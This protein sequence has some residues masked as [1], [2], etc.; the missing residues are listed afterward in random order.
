MIVHLGWSHGCCPVRDTGGSLPC[1]HYLHAH[2]TGNKKI[3]KAF[4]YS[5]LSILGSRSTVFLSR[6]TAHS[7]ILY[8]VCA[9]RGAG[10]CCRWDMAPRALR[11]NTQNEKNGWRTFSLA[12]PLV[13]AAGAVLVWSVA[14]VPSEEGCQGL[15]VEAHY[16]PN[17]IVIRLHGRDCLVLL[18]VFRKRW[19]QWACEP[20]L[21]IGS[22][23]LS[24]AQL[25]LSPPKGLTTMR[26]VFFTPVM[27]NVNRSKETNGTPS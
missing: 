21:S 11:E 9:T 20:T 2:F 7:C 1:G 17:T 16:P 8:Q 14:F 23:I 3:A 15:H 6:W 12:G 25:V 26:T 27:K 22:A 19:I 4:Y 13:Q 5:V 24:K 10:C 18:W